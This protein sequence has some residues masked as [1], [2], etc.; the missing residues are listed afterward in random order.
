M[1]VNGRGNAALFGKLRSSNFKAQ[2]SARAARTL[3]TH[4]AGPVP[5]EDLEEIIRSVARQQ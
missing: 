3:S 2:V 4:Q 1:A 5:L